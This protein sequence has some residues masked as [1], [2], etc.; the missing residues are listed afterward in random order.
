[1]SDSHSVVWLLPQV[2]LPPFQ[3]D[4]PSRAK[5][6]WM[7][8]PLSSFV[9]TTLRLSSRAVRPAE[10]G[11]PMCVTDCDSTK[12]LQGPYHQILKAPAS[13]SSSPRL[14][15][16]VACHPLVS[17]VSAVFTEATLYLQETMETTSVN[18][19][20]WR[21]EQQPAKQKRTHIDIIL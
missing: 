7:P 15:L 20:G 6:D 21:A 12:T 19:A 18:A 8:L 9:A 14:A 11:A 3:S 13:A 10:M 17:A 4:L 1:M 2:S 16:A 5:L